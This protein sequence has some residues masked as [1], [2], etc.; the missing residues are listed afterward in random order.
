MKFGRR[1]KLSGA[2]KMLNYRINYSP[3]SIEALDEIATYLADFSEIAPFTVTD[4][5]MEKIENLETMP[6]MGQVVEDDPRWRRIVAGN[7]LVFYEV[8]DE[9]RQVRIADIIHSARQLEIDRFFGKRQ[10]EVK[11]FDLEEERER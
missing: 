10:I 6:R 8:L 3:E 1:L 9:K 4:E 2:K 11:D 7:Y 5:I